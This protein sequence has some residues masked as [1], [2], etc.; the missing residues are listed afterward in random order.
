MSQ[1]IKQLPDQPQLELLRTEAKQLVQDQQI[2]SLS[3]AEQ[4]ISESYGF[5]NWITLVEY[6]EVV[7]SGEIDRLE[8]SFIFDDQNTLRQLLKQDPQLVHRCAHWVKRQRHNKYQPLAY[9][10]YLGRIEIM[11]MLIT[12]GADI[13][14]DNGQAM[15]AATY[16]P[17]AKAGIELLIKYGA[18][19]NSRK[20]KG[21]GIS[22]SVVDF[23]CMVLNPDALQ[24]LL[25]NGA[26]IT[27]DGLARV[28]ASNERKPR[29]KSQCLKLIADAG[30]FLPD[31]P[32]MALHRRD[33]IRLRQFLNEDTSLLSRVFSET[34]IFPPELGIEAPSP[35]AYV[36]PLIGGVSL[37]HMAVEFCD[38]E[39]SAW[40][41]QQGANVNQPAAVNTEG[42]GGW[43]PIFHSLATL[44]VPRNFSEIAALLMSHGADPYIRA[45]ISKPTI[46]DEGR[47]NFDHVTAIEYAH[48]FIYPDLVNRNALHLVEDWLF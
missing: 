45:S 44:H 4:L 38:L 27:R 18:D 40:L 3:E 1:I 14:C 30:L 28:V 13:N 19:P 24:C 36:T 9:A 20:V 37:L 48:N 29:H 32:P 17:E 23:A 39:L 47:V 34:D 15:M 7:N 11:E 21:N 31:T 6:V 46:E 5:P 16:S 25:D 42:Y 12:A 8:Q 41:L 43:T 10:A 35:C 26:A 22:Y 2:S 33:I